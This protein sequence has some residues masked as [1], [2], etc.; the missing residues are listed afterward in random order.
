M[1]KG[2]LILTVLIAHFSMSQIAD[3]ETEWVNND[4]KHSSIKSYSFENLD[5]LF[6]STKV[7]KWDVFPDVVGSVSKRNFKTQ[8]GTGAMVEI[9]YNK[10]IAFQ[11]R[12]S[13]GYTNI[14]NTSYTPE[15]QTKAYL[16][17]NLSKNKTTPNYLYNDI[18]FRFTYRPIK[19]VEIQAGIDN[20]HIGEGDRSL[21]SGYQS[22]PSPFA[23][24]K[25]NLWR[26]EYHFI[27]QLW[28]ENMFTKN[29]APV[30]NAS[31][32]LSYKINKNFHIG[33]FET[34]VYGMKDSLYNRGFSLEYVNPFVLF[35]PQEFGLGSPDNVILGFDAS[36]QLGNHMVY[37]SFILDEFLLSEIR[38]RKRWWANKYAVQLGVKSHFYAGD[39]HFFHRFEATLVRPFTF[40]QRVIDAVYGNDKIPIAHPLGANFIEL[41]DEINWR[42]KNFDF[43]LYLQYYLKG[44]SNGDDFTGGDIFTSYNA[45]KE[46]YHYTI[47][48]GLTT[49]RY[50]MG[51]HLAYGIRQNKWQVFV[52]PRLIVDK[53]EKNILYNAFVSVGIH[54][55]IGSTRRNY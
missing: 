16:I 22:V 31:H 9:G 28:S 15:L 4:L 40:T 21:M 47:G 20:Q 48:R 29:Y 10:K 30:G 33:F 53:I 54:R 2:L 49:W 17:N 7:I 14:A 19:E 3:V 39:H 13:V 38:A 24:V 50:A 45:R 25:L 11:A 23:K 26:F 36:Y 12:Y 46:Q 55:K 52:E 6:D 5:K 44:E 34:V 42:Y 18:R 32:Y 43:S 51:M 35:R 37:G 1:K 8:I 41:Y 27:Q